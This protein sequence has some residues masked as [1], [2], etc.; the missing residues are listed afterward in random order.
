ME[1]R[2]LH[3]LMTDYGQHAACN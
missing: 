3:Q 1:L 2:Q